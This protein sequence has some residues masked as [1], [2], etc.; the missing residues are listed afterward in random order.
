MKRADLLFLVVSFHVA[1]LLASCSSVDQPSSEP[2]LEARTYLS[3]APLIQVETAERLAL[4]E[5]LSYG[6]SLQANDKVYTETVSAVDLYGA[7]FVHIVITSPIQVGDIWQFAEDLERLGWPEPEEDS[8]WGITLVGASEA[9]EPISQIEFGL[10]TFRDIY[11]TVKAMGG[12]G[13]LKQVVAPL[14]TVFWLKDKKGTL[15]NIGTHEPVE[16]EIYTSLKEMYDDILAGLDGSDTLT[17]QSA[18]AAPQIEGSAEIGY[19]VVEGLRPQA[20]YPYSGNWNNP[21]YDE[22]KH[23]GTRTILGRSGYAQNGNFWGRQKD[24]PWKYSQCIAR[25]DGYTSSLGCG[26]AAFGALVYYH[27]NQGEK[28]GGK[29][30]KMT[31]PLNGKTITVGNTTPDDF[32]RWITAPTGSDGRPRLGYYMASCRFPHKSVATSGDNF[33]DGGKEFLRLHAPQLKL[34]YN[35]SRG[36]SN[37][38]NVDNKFKVVNYAKS[39]NLPAVVL[40][41]SSFGTFHFSFIDKWRAK[42]TTKGLFVMPEHHEGKYTNMGDTFRGE[43]G[44]WTVYN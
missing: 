25:S 27:F 35:W 24:Y 38:R 18:W 12:P 32:K 40:F 26:P 3:E 44:V 4:A 14:S 31:L 42:S 19:S 13:Q 39:R 8:A 17:P 5:R 22:K 7:P 9:R 1:L 34:Y 36:F 11:E 21:E 29:T 16:E 2:N 37:P 15:W 30:R 23:E 20:T 43:V 41:P 10:D 6:L 28:I 33:S